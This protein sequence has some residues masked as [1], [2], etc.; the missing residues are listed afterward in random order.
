MTGAILLALVLDAA[1][2]SEAHR[3]EIDAWR[4][5]RLERLSRPDGWLTLAGLFWLEEGSNP[6]GSDKANAVVLPLPTPPCMGELVLDRGAVRVRVAPGV[7]L[8]AGG[9]PVS[10]AALRTDADGD[11]TSLDYG[12]VSFYVIKRRDRFAVR[13]RNSAS[14]ALAG[15]TGID[16]FPI[17]PAWRLTARFEK[18]DPPKEVL[19]P[20]VIG[21]V[22]RETCPG[23]IHFEVGGQTYHLEP[24]LESGSDELF[25]IFGDRTNGLETYG[26]GRFLYAK[27][28]DAE[29]RL[30]LDFN[31][32]YNPPCVFTPYATCPLPPSGNRLPIRIEAGEKTY[33]EQH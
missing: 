3:A 21:G 8:T 28:P 2:S 26:A 18:Y 23:A 4:L 19:V 31:K 32:A 25:I 24:V 13:V 11:P 29:G 30:I 15:F 17:D 7:E 6:F 33:G 1:P 12:P 27:W 9:K 14:P 10:A 20:S 5:R 22:D 16:S